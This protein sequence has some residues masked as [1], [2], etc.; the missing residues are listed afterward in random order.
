MTRLQPVA[1]LGEAPPRA[2][3]EPQGVRS[4]SWQDVADLSSRAGV[5]LDPWQESILRVAMGE[6][7]DATWAAKRV[8]VSLPR[9]NGKSQL[10]VSRA[11]A[12]LLL[13]GERKIV[14]SAHQVDTAREAFSKMVEILEADGNEW[15]MDR[16]KPNGIMNAFARE[17]VKFKNGATVQF[18]AR[19][20]SGGRGF[21]SDC[22][23]LDEAQ[24]LKR[25]AW[26]SINSTMSAMPNPQV[27]LLGTPPTR[28]DVDGGM[29][30]V[31]ESVRLA[32][33]SGA[34][35]ATAW[36]EWG[37]DPDLMAE[38]KVAK[39]LSAA[40]REW[41]PE[42]EA[43]TW[44][45]NPAWNS[46]INL[47]VV[48][49]EFESYTPEEYA[50]DRL[51]VWLADI[52]QGTRDISAEAWTSTEGFPAA[53]GVPSYGVAF[54]PDGLKMALGGGFKAA[55]ETVHLE[56]VDDVFE[57]AVDGGFRPLVDWFLEKN[58]DGVARWRRAG[59]I[60]LSG[61][62]GAP[63]LRLMLREAGI[64]DKR[65]VVASTPQYLQACEMVR[66]GVRALTVTH[67]AEGQ[68][69]LDASVAVS[70]RDRRGGWIATTPDGDETP[71]EAVSL[72]LWGAR[73]SK[74]RP[75]E[76]ERKVLVL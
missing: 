41:T 45:A 46:R 55:D 65:I 50:L 76:A 51:G 14:I 21:S 68:E 11:L 20:A 2:L 34:S 61:S 59:L 66:E 27:W 39:A 12:G 28:E 6:R 60:V 35:T 8:G 69:V 62:A 5:T 17:Q 64:P 44:S 63:V 71:L 23:L 13:F 73:T 53:D 42:V 32:A 70:D 72:A 74:R 43:V 47:E 16:V 4:N 24:R 38:P 58:D 15:L 40:I 75:G 54:S 52:G 67:L 57:G 7:S 31:F 3:V 18:K 36:A 49:G 37:A 33:T 56:L 9:Q 1:L 25:P 19:T 22:L 30:E 29:G 48:Q 26:V 10:L